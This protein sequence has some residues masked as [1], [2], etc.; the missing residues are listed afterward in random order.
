MVRVF[1]VF[2]SMRRE[3][4]PLVVITAV[5]LMG[6]ACKPASAEPGGG[7]GEDLV[8]LQVDEHTFHVE[9]ADTEERRAEGLMNRDSLAED[10]GMLFVFERDQRMSFWM[11][12]T[13]I[14][15]SIAYIAS[16]GTIREI[17][18]MEPHDLT[19]V[20]SARS[21]RYALEVNQGA[22]D[23]LGISEG[24]KVQIPEEYR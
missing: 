1:S 2:T 16:D 4:L 23:A 19:P 7:E 11:K 5:V 20:R 24:D 9:I 3:G 6:A 17:H 21:V 10:R 13:S 14:P 22:F 8:E 18:A 15:L 12:D